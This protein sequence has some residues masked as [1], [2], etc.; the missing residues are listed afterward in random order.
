[1]AS[2]TESGIAR[3][4]ANSDKFLKSIVQIRGYNPSN[5]D[6]SCEAI[7]K[8][9]TNVKDAMIEVSRASAVYKNAIKLREIGF[10]LLSKFASRIYNTLKASD[11]NRSDVTAREYV[12]KIQGRRASAK[13]TADEKKSDIEAGIQYNEVSASQMSY[14]SR[15]D[16][17]GMLINVL[18]ATPSYAPNEE[19]LKLESLNAF[20]E[21]LKQ[22][23]IAVIEAQ[24]I[25]YKA[26]ALRNELLNKDETGLIDIILS[27]KAYLKGA[28]GPSSP[29]YKEV[30]GLS[31]RKVSVN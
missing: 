14:D 15:L 5:P 29:Q 28:F 8:T 24:T 11:K 31:F 22:K 26:R 10:E 21:D 27:A 6:L 2:L 9:S 3:T 25:L 23:N 19:D 12:R 20:F 17:L 13:R 30:S 7:Q 16:N 4:V 1:M 18:V